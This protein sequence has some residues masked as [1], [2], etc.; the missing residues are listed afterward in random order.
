MLAMLFK[1]CK[2]ETNLEL[3][4]PYQV[5]LYMKMYSEDAFILHIHNSLLQ[6]QLEKRKKYKNSE[7]SLS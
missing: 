6:A 1:F 5:L 3:N 4:F 2:I 7:V